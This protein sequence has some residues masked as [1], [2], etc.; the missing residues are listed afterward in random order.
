MS[1]SSIENV[2]TIM[3]SV[4]TRINPTGSIKTQ[5]DVW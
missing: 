3:N 1:E 2:V 4:G 5:E